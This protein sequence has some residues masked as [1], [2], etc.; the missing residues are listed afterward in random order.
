[1][2]TILKSNSETVAYTPGRA[3][4]IGVWGWRHC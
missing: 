4:S 2:S 3:S 1:M